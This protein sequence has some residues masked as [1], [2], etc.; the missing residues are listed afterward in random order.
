VAKMA[1]ASN[2]TKAGVPYFAHF[3]L[4][5]AVGCAGGCTADFSGSTGRRGAG[6][7][8]AAMFKY[9]HSYRSFHAAI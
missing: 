7:L 5:C 1:A 4:P 8:A 3:A 9:P 2:T 6:V